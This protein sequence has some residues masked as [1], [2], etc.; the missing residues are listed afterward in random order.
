MTFTAAR[1]GLV[2]CHD[3]G[4]LSRLPGPAV[5]GC[6]PRCA[7]PLH[8][9]KPDSVKRTWALLIAASI[10]YLPANVF[11]ILITR[12]LFG[13]QRDTI[14]SGVVYLW[15]SGSWP[16]ALVVFVASIVVPLLKLVAIALLLVSI[17]MRSRR[18]ALER[19]RLYRLMAFIGRWSMVDIYAVTL[20]VALVRV[21][22][23]A[24]MSVGPGALAFGAVVVL[25]MLASMSLDP[26]L[27]WDPLD[28]ADG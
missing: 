7:A 2:S 19:A 8:K 15:T 6:C 25:T 20:L 11:P 10:L 18:H 17:Q 24:V 12:S 5:H 13:E 21:Q 26:R 22:T 9:R 14:L 28:R 23:L 27:I 16:L 1:L 4:L 3:C